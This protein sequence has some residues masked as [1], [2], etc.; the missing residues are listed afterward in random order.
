VRHLDQQKHSINQQQQK[1]QLD[2][3]LLTAHNKKTK[4]ETTAMTI[5]NVFLLF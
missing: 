4:D 3:T 5:N 2:T 1:Y